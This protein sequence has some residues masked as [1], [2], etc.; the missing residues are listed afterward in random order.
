MFQPM[1]DR[2]RRTYAYFPVDQFPMGGGTPIH[3]EPQGVG[4]TVQAAFV[5]W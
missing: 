1:I 2:D 4:T 5:S 3:G